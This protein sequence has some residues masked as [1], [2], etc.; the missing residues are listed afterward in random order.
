MDKKE[1]AVYLHDNF[2]SYNHIDECG[3][4]YEKDGDDH[5][6]RGNSHKRW[7]ERAK[8]FIEF[9]KNPTREDD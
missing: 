7:L 2:C 3:W 8:D 4:A 6:W 1:I 9:L 5:N